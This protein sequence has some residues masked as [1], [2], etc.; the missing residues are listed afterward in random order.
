MSHSFEHELDVAIA[1]ASRAGGLLR[2][3]LE[4]GV[5]ARVKSAA[6]D[7]VT[8]ADK[9]SESIIVTALAEAFPDHR[10]LSEEG[11]GNHAQSEFVW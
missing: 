3:Y 8:E 11:G 1:A 7:L 4:R 10:I 6:I 9:S 2:M 5:E